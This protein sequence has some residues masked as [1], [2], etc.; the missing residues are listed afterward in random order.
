MDLNELA[1]KLNAGQ[2]LV[3][4]EEG[5]LAINDPNKVLIVYGSLAPGRDNHQEMRNIPGKWKEAIIHGKLMES[6]WGQQLGYPG[7]RFEPIEELKEISCFV[8]F[9]QDLPN[10]LGILDEFEGEDYC[11][12]MAPYRLLD[13][14]QGIGNIYA[15][16]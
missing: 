10:H 15:L 9:S 13:G 1:R 16:K 2:P 5:W 7:I 14:T 6:G 11:R 4:N 12:V 3:P 8:L